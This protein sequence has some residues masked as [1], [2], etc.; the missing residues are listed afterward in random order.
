MVNPFTNHPRR[1]TGE[2]WGAH[3]KFALGV[4]LRLIITGGIF[5][6]H[7][8]FPFV[9]IPKWLNLHD[10]IKFLEKENEDREN[11]KRQH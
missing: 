4:G 10:S 11:T 9:K 8:V 1:C 3:C 2:S 6:V 7:G 5:I